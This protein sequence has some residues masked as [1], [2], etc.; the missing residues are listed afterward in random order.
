[1]RPYK[2]L[3]LAGL[4]L[5]ISTLVATLALAAECPPSGAPLTEFGIHYLLDKT[6]TSKE[7]GTVIPLSKPG[8]P[9]R[10]ARLLVVSSDINTGWRLVI[11]N[12]QR[13]PL[14]VIDSKNFSDGSKTTWSNRLPASMVEL[15]LEFDKPLPELIVKVV[16]ATAMPEKAEHPYYST[17]HPIADWKDLYASEFVEVSP[18][19]RYWGDS[20]GMLTSFA[21]SSLT[22]VATW[23][24]SGSIIATTP[25][26][27]FLTNFHCGGLKSWQDNEFWNADV[28][29]NT[30]VDM[31]WDGDDVSMEYACKE[32]VKVDPILDAAVLELAPL[33][34][35]SMPAKSIKIRIKPGEAGESLKIIHHP[36]CL[37][38]QISQGC[39]VGQPMANWKDG[40]KITDFA[41]TCDSE[42]GSSGAPVFDSS[43]NLVGLHHLGF[44]LDSGGHCDQLN[45]AVSSESLLDFLKN[46]PIET[47][48]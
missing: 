46:F 29:A 17:K 36:Q 35:S 42:G 11:R 27:L 7:P 19:V 8:A 3:G 10:Y 22:G 9:V 32:V 13:K 45:K 5:V 31:S 4:G 28:C 16:A 40:R 26:I 30:V 18:E 14:Q 1:M 33:T 34:S 37:S 47:A 48:N 24:C 25:R 6:L 23:C 38:K 20:V 2:I 43:G 12:Q 39:N 41:H 15:S 44:E 21:G